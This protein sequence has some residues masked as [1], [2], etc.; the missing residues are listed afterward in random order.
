MA[1][2]VGSHLVKTDPDNPSAWINLAYSVRRA[3]SI[4]RAEE[5]LLKARDLH[6][7]SAL[8]VFYLACYASVAGRMEEAKGRLRHAINL[9][10]DIRRLALDDKDLRPMC[11]WIGGVTS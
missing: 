10:K 8:I 2:T 1:V 5:I 9:D 6:P 4:E 7:K 3:E 11:D